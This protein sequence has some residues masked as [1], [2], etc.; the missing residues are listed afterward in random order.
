MQGKPNWTHNSYAPW[1]SLQPQ[2]IGYEFLFI[3]NS[4]ATQNNNN[5]SIFAMGIDDSFF[6]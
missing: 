4:N 6:A 3:F 5:E 1:R 2:K